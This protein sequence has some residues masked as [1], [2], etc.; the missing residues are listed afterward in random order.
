[1]LFSSLSLFCK[2]TKDGFTKIK[3]IAIIIKF[4]IKMLR[5]VALANLSSHVTN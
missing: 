3:L 1:M 2:R 4:K 5:L